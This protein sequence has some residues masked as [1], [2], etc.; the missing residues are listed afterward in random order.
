MNQQIIILQGGED[1]RK[2]TNEPLIRKVGELSITRK[3]L[4]IPWTSAKKEQEYRPIFRGYF[5]DSGFL[6]VLFL[7]KDD[8]EGVI[9]EKFAS[10]DV[11]YLPGG[12]PEVLYEEL[13][14]RRVQDRLRD[15]KGIIVGN[16]AGAIVLSRGAYIEN[17]FYRGFGLV[18][19]FVSVHYTPGPVSGADDGITVNIP[20]DMWIAVSGKP[21][22]QI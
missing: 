15:F 1:V 9:G 2:R 13:R 7:E 14:N 5:S 3:I 11:V 17:K 12:D 19:F 8:P 18:G 22:M 16:S 6:E 10:V 4:V 21:G 20:E